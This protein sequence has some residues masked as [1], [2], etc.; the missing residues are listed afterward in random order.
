MAAQFGLT[1]LLKRLLETRADPNAAGGYFEHPLFAAVLAGHLNGDVVEL[2]LSHDLDFARCEYGSSLQ[3][4]ARNE[5]FQMIE[6]L[7]SAGAKLEVEGGAL[8]TALQASAWYG[9]LKFV[10]LLVEKS[11]SVNACGGSF[12]SAVSAACYVGHLSVVEFL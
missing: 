6:L 10:R 5:Q 3:A 1:K 4:A 2:L 12:D 8:G 7:M 11:V 9:E